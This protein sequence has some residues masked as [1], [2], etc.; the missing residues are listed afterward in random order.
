M[1]PF[2]VGWAA[3]DVVSDELDVG[4]EGHAAREASLLWPSALHR[5]VALIHCPVILSKPH[6]LAALLYV[7]ADGNSYLGGRL[8]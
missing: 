5:I 6:S 2:A 1:L 3:F 8:Y 7:L 4:I